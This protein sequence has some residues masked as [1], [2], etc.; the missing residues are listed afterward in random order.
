MHIWNKIPRSILTPRAVW[1]RRA[2]Y[3]RAPRDSP[4]TVNSKYAN[5]SQKGPDRPGCTSASNP[6]QPPAPASG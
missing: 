4:Y 6:T 3:L 1:R 5:H 2:A